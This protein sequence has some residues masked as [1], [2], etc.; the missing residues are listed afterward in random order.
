MPGSRA[1]CHRL[2]SRADAMSPDQTRSA[3][4]RERSRTAARSAPRLPGLR[5]VPVPLA[6]LA[7]ALGWL[8]LGGTLGQHAA[9]VNNQHVHGY[10]AGGLSLNVDTMLWLSNDMTGQGPVKNPN[11]H[12]F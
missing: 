4:R 2:N 12:G 8:V 7:A 10:Q 3:G 1:A 6:M 5:W 11:P 9:A